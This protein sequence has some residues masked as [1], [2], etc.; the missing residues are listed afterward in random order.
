MSSNAV[1]VPTIDFQAAVTGR[2][3]T[4]IWHMMT[5]FRRTY[6]GATVSLGIAAVA[7]TA[8][9][10]LLRTLVDD[11]LTHPDALRL[12]PVVALGFVDDGLG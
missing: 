2:R 4:G 3:L 9:L 6:L 5:G 7:R 8:T 10:L 1:A 12:L 11:V